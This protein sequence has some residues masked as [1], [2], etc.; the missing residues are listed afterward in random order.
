MS[1]S[2]FKKDYFRYTGSYRIRLVELLRDHSLRY[3]L[4]LRGGSLLKPVRKHLSTKYGINLGSGGG[5]SPGVYLGH[6]YGINVNP[7]ARIGP[8]CNLHKGCTVGQENR[9]KRKGAP[10]IGSRVWIGSGAVVVGSIVVGDDVLIAPNAYVNR[11]VPSHSIVIGNPCVIIEK[12][13]A[14]SGYVEN[15]VV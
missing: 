13:E 15:C 7:N 2:D 10:T 8:N 5:V 11:D 12:D 1:F 3:L 6:A 14:T 9:G 4:A